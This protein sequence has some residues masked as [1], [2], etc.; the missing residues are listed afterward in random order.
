VLAEGPYGQ[1]QAW[2][3]HGADVSARTA[4]GGWLR[5]T[6]AARAAHDPKGTSPA[7]AHAPG[8]VLPLGGTLAE[9]LATTVPA[10]EPVVREDGGREYA[11]QVPADRALRLLPAHLAAPAASRA[12]RPEPVPLTVVLDARGRLASADLDLGFALDRLTGPTGSRTLPGVTALH[13][14]FRTTGYG[15][16]APEAPPAGRTAD[17]H[18]AVVPLFRQPKGTCVL[19]AAGL[20]DGTRVLRADCARPHIMRLFALGR[21]ADIGRLS[22]G[23]YTERTC[24]GP[25][26]ALP[27]SWRRGTKPAY[28]RVASVRTG[29]FSFRSDGSGKVSGEPPAVSV[30]VA[31]LLV[32]R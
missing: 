2:A 10:R 13:A 7:A 26:R 24:G 9:L 5:W 19:P 14:V 8:R 27:A 21:S 1:P 30:T 23:R 11:V 22:V 25:F 31:C 17:A 29:A 20:G 6:P 15:V 28:E 32:R 3:V 12:A 4:D 16:P 18:R